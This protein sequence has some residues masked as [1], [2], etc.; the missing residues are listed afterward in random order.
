MASVIKNAT[1]AAMDWIS[2][3]FEAPFGG[4][5]VFGVH[6]DGWFSSSWNVAIGI[7]LLFSVILCHHHSVTKSLTL[8]WLLWWL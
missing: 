5:V 2:L 7:S 3:A 6:I 1:A 8:C 4:A